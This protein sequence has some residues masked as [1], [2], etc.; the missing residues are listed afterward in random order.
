MSTR[1]KEMKSLLDAGRY[2]KLVCGAGNENAEEVRRLTVIYALAGS[3][4]FDVSATPSVVEACVSGIEMAY[5]LAEKLG[6]SIPVRP[7]ITVSVGMGGD[8]HVRKAYIVDDC[9]DCGKCIPVCPT[10]AIPE[11]YEIIREK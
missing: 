9:V 11:S 2:V 10:D 8:H 6:K 5:K 1:F 4:G 7:F 3:N